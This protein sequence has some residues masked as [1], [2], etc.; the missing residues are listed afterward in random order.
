MKRFI[1]KK[2]LIQSVKNLKGELQEIKKENKHLKEQ[3]E[4]YKN[5]NKNGCK[6]NGSCSLCA[7]SVSRDVIANGMFYHDTACI[8]ETEICKSFLAK[9]LKD[10][11]K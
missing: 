9:N 3:L 2:F 8:K 1:K 11:V 6:K 10:N 4:D 7:W 5:T